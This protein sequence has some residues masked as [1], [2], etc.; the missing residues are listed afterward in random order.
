[1]A[2]KRGQRKRRKYSAVYLPPQLVKKIKRRI[3]GTNFKSVSE[4]VTLVL[5]EFLSN[6]E[7]ESKS[8]SEKDEMRIK[9]RLRV[10]GYI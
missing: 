6:L 8:F 7:E 5:E 1:M 3:E 4:Y 9:E 2:R 10:L